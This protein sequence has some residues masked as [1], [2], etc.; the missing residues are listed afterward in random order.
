MI[1]RSNFRGIIHPNSEDNFRHLPIVLFDLSP[2]STFDKE[3]VKSSGSIAD[4]KENMGTLIKSSEVEDKGRYPEELATCR[5]T[6]TGL[7]LFLRPI[8]VS[9]E[10]LLMDLMHGLSDK[11]LYT[12]FFTTWRAMLEGQIPE[13]AMVDYERAMAIAAIAMKDSMP[14]KEEFIGV[15]RYYI[16]PERHTAVIAFAVRDDYQNQGIGQVLLS[17]L[18]DLARRQGLLGFTAA[19]LTDN[20]TMLH[21]FAKTFKIKKEMTVSTGV[22]ILMMTFREMKPEG[23]VNPERPDSAIVSPSFA[24]RSHHS[25]NTTSQAHSF[26]DHIIHTI[27]RQPS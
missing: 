19:V 10:P 18:T 4:G 11:S 22:D 21:V 23:T 9:D 6:K 17:Y 13:L 2:Y 24:E 8:K 1:G 5:R 27:V 25:W 16:N 14:E 3:D 20:E 7:E 26:E 15:G 12:R